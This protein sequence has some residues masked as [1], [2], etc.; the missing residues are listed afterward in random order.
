M[1]RSQNRESLPYVPYELRSH[2]WADCPPWA[3]RSR[4]SMK[5]ATPSL[6]QMSRHPCTETESPN[7]WCASSC[8]SSDPDP[9]PSTG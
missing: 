2:S 5:V 9:L 1:R 7:H 3:S 6:S 8:T 4:A